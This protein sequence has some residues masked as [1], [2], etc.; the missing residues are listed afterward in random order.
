MLGLAG[1]ATSEGGDDCASLRGH[2]R[3]PGPTSVPCAPQGASVVY[4]TRPGARSSVIQFAPGRVH[5]GFDTPRGVS[6]GVPPVARGVSWGGRGG[7]RAGIAAG[8]GRLRAGSGNGRRGSASTDRAAR[9]GRGGP[10][11][12]GLSG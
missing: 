1:G 3:T 10:G 9:R 4:S 11:R 5:R 8:W 6:G 2:A 7:R 12:R